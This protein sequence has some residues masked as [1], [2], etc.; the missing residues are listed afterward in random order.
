MSL[1]AFS[2]PLPETRFFKAGSF[3]YKFKIRGGSSYSGEEVIGENYINQELEDIIRTVLANLDSLQPFSSAHFNV[4]PY[5]KPWE[6]VSKLMF[7]HG[8]EK[9]AAYPFIIT[10]YMEN[11]TQTGKQAEN[12][13]TSEKEAPRHFPSSSEPLPK[14]SKRDSPLEE[15]IIK[16]LMDSDAE[17][18]AHMAGTYVDDLHVEEEV[19]EVEEDDEQEGTRQFVESQWEAGINSQVSSALGEVHAGT[20][21]EVEEEEED[22]EEE[23]GNVGSAPQSPVRPGLLT[24]LASHIFPFSFFFREH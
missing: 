14:R 9:L 1:Q 22:E 18:Q 8:E 23:G 10:L 19:E 12:N 13:L 20:A 17:T 16:E 6:R 24:R 15:A 3:V 11:N 4:F 7:K 2:F 5:K 21:E